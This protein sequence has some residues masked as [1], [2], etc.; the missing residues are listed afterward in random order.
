M[1]LD[2]SMRI[3][4]TPYYSFAPIDSVGAVINIIETVRSRGK[5][6]TAKYRAIRRFQRRGC[7]TYWVRRTEN[8]TKK[9]KR[10][11][12]VGKKGAKLAK[13]CGVSV[14]DFKVD[15]DF[16]LFRWRGKWRRLIEFLTLSTPSAERSSDESS[17]DTM[18]LDEGIV[19]PRQRASFPGDEYDAL[20]DIFWTKKRDDCPLR[21]YILSNK[22]SAYNPYYQ[23]FGIPQKPIDWEGIATYRGG[24]IAV[25][26]D[27]TIPAD[28]NDYDDK[29]RR[30]IAPTKYG[31]FVYAGRPR[32]YGEVAIRKK[33]P[34]ATKYCQF[35]FG[36]PL[37][38]WYAD[39]SAYFTSGVD[40]AAKVWVSDLTTKYKTAR[41]FSRGDR[42]R[43]ASLIALRRQNR[44]YFE[45]EA[46]AE[47]AIATL[48]R[49]I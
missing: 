29:V 23:Y 49:L 1:G 18:I 24:S 35:D 22:E 33:P 10:S 38:V 41:V 42:V 32:A 39:G 45:D 8:D 15:G 46:T 11:W 21:L 14:D 28:R 5:T 7:G 27:L 20:M 16:I 17:F 2:W 40:R 31:S 44:I 43:F 19:S 6:F 47:N 4:K 48:E 9:A 37:S 34:N 30:A 36:A 26:V 13:M 12:I 3:P 25:Q